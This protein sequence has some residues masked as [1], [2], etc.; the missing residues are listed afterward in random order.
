MKKVLVLVMILFACIET[1]FASATF[2]SK[3]I[4][5]YTFKVFKYD[6]KSD[7]FIF[8]IWVNLDNKATDLRTL[9]EK[10]NGIFA[11]NWAY[12]CPSDYRECWWTDTTLNERYFKWYKVWPTSS[13]EHR[14]VFAVDKDNSPFLF[15]TWN[16]NAKSEDKIY[17]WI[18]NFP[19]LLRSWVNTYKYY[20]D[21]GLID[22]KMKAK[23]PRNFI[24]SDFTNRFI[25]AWYVS[26]IELEKLPEVLL[27]LGCW[28]ALNL[29]AGASNA[30]I[31][32]WKYMIWPGRDILDA[33]VIERKW[34]DVIALNSGAIQVIDNF[35]VKLEEK[36]YDEKIFALDTISNNLNNYVQGIYN[37]NSKDTYGV[38]G[39]RDGYEISIRNVSKLSIVYLIN[40]LN[41]LVN[42]VKREFVRA[43]EER[44]KQER[45]EENRKSGLF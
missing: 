8:K 41:K 45:D 12:F 44:I 17:Y 20:E 25:Y 24:C 5:W 11:I 9:M 16:I 6:T 2:I 40:Y 36:T 38:D 39:L 3:N 4:K 29:D 28:H 37:K 19:L 34:L 7:E 43:E 21:L 30:M 14:V 22:Y 15:Q 33:V 13:T 35:K 1:T 10:N 23:L 42:D 27:E 26:N 31:Y 32:N 18:A